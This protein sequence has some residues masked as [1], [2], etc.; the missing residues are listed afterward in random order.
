MPQK[1]FVHE[2]IPKDP[3]NKAPCFPV[4][5][6]QYSIS[7]SLHQ[8][9]SCSSIWFV[10]S[11]AP[12]PPRWEHYAGQELVWFYFWLSMASTELTQYR[13]L[14]GEKGGR[15]GK[16][17]Q[18]N[19]GPSHP[20]VILPLLKVTEGCFRSNLGRTTG[21]QN[22]EVPFI[23]RCVLFSPLSHH[24]PK[25]SIPLSLSSFSFWLQ[26]ETAS[27]PPPVTYS[28]QCPV[29]E[30]PRKCWPLKG[31]APLFWIS[32]Q[33][34]PVNTPKVYI[35]TLHSVCERPREGGMQRRN[36]SHI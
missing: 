31:R 22:S 14:Q 23:S 5:L 1:H 3:S 25:H 9:V 34:S 13:H 24:S 18:M 35:L 30:K 12:P 6:C 19:P 20:K 28:K 10:I 29:L 36:R 4:T 33:M 21:A 26:R 8:N 17:K 27:G 15:E 11:C 7:F 2:A 32:G 16:E